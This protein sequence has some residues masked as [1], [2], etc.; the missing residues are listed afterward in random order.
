MFERLIFKQLIMFL[1]QSFLNIIADFGMVI[2]HNTAYSFW[3][4]S[5]KKYLDRNDSHICK[6]AFDCLWHSRSKT[7]WLRIWPKNRLL[8]RLFELLETKDKNKRL[9]KYTTTKY[10][11]SNWTNMLHWVVQGVISGPLLFNVFFCDLFLF[12]GNT[13]LV[14]HVDDNTPFQMRSSELEVI[15]EIK[16][17]L[18]SVSLWF[19]NNCMKVNL[20]KSYLH[21]SGKK[22]SSGWYL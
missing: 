4:K 3:L 16:S 2:M 21:F 5:E 22:N 17:A 13:D 11:I 9:D 15:N 8:R 18:E 20:D 6:K 19:Q 14:I 1:N 10:N 12:I 7:S